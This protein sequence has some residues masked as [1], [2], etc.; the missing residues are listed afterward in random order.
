MFGNQI[1]TLSEHDLKSISLQQEC[2]N[3]AL[4]LRPS[5]CQEL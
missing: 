4:F 3:I 1:E 2:G 5:T